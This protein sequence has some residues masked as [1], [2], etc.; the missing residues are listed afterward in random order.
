MFSSLFV[1]ILIPLIILSFWFTNG[2]SVV[3]LAMYSLIEVVGI[4]PTLFKTKPIAELNLSHEEAK[5]FSKYHV[6]FRYRIGA[7]DISRIFAMVQIS[8]FILTPLFWYKDLIAL[9]LILVANYFIVSIFAVK[10]NPALYLS[11]D[12]KKG[13]SKYIDE[14]NLLKSVSEKIYAFQEAQFKKRHPNAY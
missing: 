10:L 13:N 5:I 7:Q 2:T 3:I 8:T 4:L 14:Y 6:F 12:I 9:A 11:E 1:I